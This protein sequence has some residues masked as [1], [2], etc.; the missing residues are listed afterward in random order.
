MVYH[1]AYNDITVKACVSKHKTTHSKQCLTVASPACR[2]CAAPGVGRWTAAPIV[3]E[4][5]LLNVGWTGPI[6]AELVHTAE[7][8]SPLSYR[9][10]AK[11]W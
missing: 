5:T 7:G 8:T 9:E 6:A 4:V 2:R 11:R 1:L 10:L 3:R